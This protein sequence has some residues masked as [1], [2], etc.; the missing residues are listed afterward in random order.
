MSSSVGL[1]LD[2]GIRVNKSSTCDDIRNTVLNHFHAHPNNKVEVYRLERFDHSDTGTDSTNIVI[3][4]P[5]TLLTGKTVEEIVNENHSKQND[6]VNLKIELKQLR[7][8]LAQSDSIRKDALEAVD[9]LRREFVSLMSELS[10]L[11]SKRVP[12]SARRACLQRPIGNS[13]RIT[14][15]A[16]LIP[17]LRLNQFK[18]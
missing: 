12:S 4:I 6:I 5:G 14:D 16:H 11:S 3:K 9:Q 8:R 15:R 10:P 13:A 17:S 7:K 18:P 1:F 2:L